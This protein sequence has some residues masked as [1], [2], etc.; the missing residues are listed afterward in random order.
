[1]IFNSPCLLGL[2][3]FVSGSPVTTHPAPHPSFHEIEIQ[4]SDQGG[5]HLARASYDG[6]G[7]VVNGDVTITA[8]GSEETWQTGRTDPS[9]L[10]AFFPD[11]PGTWA[12]QVDDGLGHRT[13]VTFVV[14]AGEVVTEP[15][16][17][18]ADPEGG[19]RIWQLLT[20]LSLIAGLTG[21]A[22]GYT[23]RRKGAAGG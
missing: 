2:F 20:G 17:I 21:A 5:I 4:V 18:A 22:Y 10:F 6:G 9:G 23:A 15:G 3:L 8:P 11:A 1:M 12:I 19:A 7:P 13:R 16:E 14:G